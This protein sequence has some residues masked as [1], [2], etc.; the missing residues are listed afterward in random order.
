MWGMNEA[1]TSIVILVMVVAAWLIVTKALSIVQR[2][3]QRIEITRGDEKI[4][5]QGHELD[6][7]TDRFLTNEPDPFSKA[8]AEDVR[9]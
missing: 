3:G 1:D 4:V 7:N 2:R 5:I 6:V 8:T 9:H